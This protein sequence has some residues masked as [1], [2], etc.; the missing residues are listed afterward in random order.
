M[1]SRR[2]AVQARLGRGLVA[3]ADARATT[4]PSPPVPLSDGAGGMSCEYDVLAARLPWQ[5]KGGDWSDRAG[6]LHGAQAFASVALVRNMKPAFTDA[7]TFDLKSLAAQWQQ[8]LGMPGAIVLRATSGAGIADI[9]SREDANESQRPV[10]HVTWD[11]GRSGGHAHQPCVAPVDAT[12]GRHH[13]GLRRALPPRSQRAAL[14]MAGQHFR[15][16]IV[17]CRYGQS[18]AFGRVMSSE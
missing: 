10:L 9:V 1:D 8:G 11:D 3:A 13:R 17:A 4:P 15:R 14:R 7:L 2:R 12:P 6:I 5:R 18:P 16:R